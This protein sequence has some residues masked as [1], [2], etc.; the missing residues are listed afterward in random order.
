MFLDRFDVPMLKMILQKWKKN[1]FD[2]FPSEKHFE[3]QLLLHSHTLP[4]FSGLCNAIEI[5][6][7]ELSTK[8]MIQQ[9]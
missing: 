8:C 7:G 3:K 9:C 4:S 5:W 6:R 2:A 1:Y